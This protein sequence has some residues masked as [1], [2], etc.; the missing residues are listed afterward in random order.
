VSGGTF[1]RSVVAAC[2][3]V[4]ALSD[5]I[6]SAGVVQAA[7]QLTE[8]DGDVCQT[9]S[10]SYAL[11]QGLTAVASV[12]VV[13]VNVG[14]KA[15]TRAM[16]RLERHVS[17]AAEERAV[18]IKIFVASFV[19]TALISLLVNARL[20]PSSG[21]PGILNAANGEFRDFE[22]PRWYSTVGASVALVMVVNVFAPH[23]HVLLRP[24]SGACRSLRAGCA[25]TQAEVDSLYQPPE[26]ALAVAWP[27]LLNTV[28]ATLF[29]SGALP[30]LL[31]LA[32]AAMLVTYAAERFLAF[33]VYAAPP[34]TTSSL[35]KLALE[36]LVFAAPLNLALA[37]WMLGADGTL[38]SWDD[39]S[40]GGSVPMGEEVGPAPAVRVDSADGF[41]TS[42]GYAL[43]WLYGS[44]L[45]ALDPRAEWGLTQRARQ[46]F[47]VP[48]HAALLVVTAALFVHYV[49]GRLLGTAL[50]RAV[51]FCTCGR[52]CSSADAADRINAAATLRLLPS[53]TG[54][55]EVKLPMGARH[56]VSEHEYA[57]GWRIRKDP[58]RGPGA[59]KKVKVFTDTNLDDPVRPHR[60]GDAM[61]TYEVISDY[62][63]ASFDI[64]AHPDYREAALALHEGVS[65]LNMARVL[66]AS[67][68]ANAL[69]EETRKRQAA[70]CVA[71][72]EQADE[73]DD[74][75]AARSHGAAHH[76]G[77]RDSGG[78]EP[79]LHS[80]QVDDEGEGAQ[81]A[82]LDH[83][84]ATQPDEDATRGPTWTASFWARRDNLAKVAPA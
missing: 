60:A 27:V 4:Q 23:M 84:L 22:A 52:C 37:S 11:A 35:A 16:T 73:A 71:Q 25:D 63:I 43:R 51:V 81:D 15:C 9:F 24:C 28:F 76:R 65:R 59:E 41:F 20:L 54:K 18:A 82:S 47:L 55:Y 45:T 1:Q 6:D 72:A 19:N 48:L 32:A 26:M 30:L 29:F 8:Q 49:V 78:A 83:L 10:E 75:T 74:D 57:E 69:A 66:A 17:R 61:L 34:L 3:C 70:R 14:L 50:R 68:F 7:R 38:Q 21:G 42:F 53:F 80:E 64:R 44:V 5:A 2:Y 40:S 12:A 39:R 36:L 13:L 46:P 33:R 77:K 79:A 67:R 58:S 56:Y 31:P 62:S